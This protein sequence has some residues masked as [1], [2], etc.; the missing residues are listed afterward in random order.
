MDRQAGRRARDSL[1]PLRLVAP[2]EARGLGLDALDG[3]DLLAEQVVDCVD[4]A[5]CTATSTTK[6]VSA[7]GQVAFLPRGETRH[8]VLAALEHARRQLAAPSLPGEGH[9]SLRD[10]VTRQMSST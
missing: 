6:L 10:A 3:D 4:H 2:P 5:I 1:L 8:G 7:P 9:G